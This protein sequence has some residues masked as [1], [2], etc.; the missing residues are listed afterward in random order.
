VG[1]NRLVTLDWTDNSS[2]EQ[3]FD[4]E[5]AAKVK[6]LEFA[7][8]A[9]VGVNVTSYSQTETSGQWVYRVQAYN[10]VGASSFS[11]NVT[12]RVR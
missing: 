10:A 4:V 2:N 8:I 11:N 7:R 9:T 1:A 3:G 6:N 5:R 12:I